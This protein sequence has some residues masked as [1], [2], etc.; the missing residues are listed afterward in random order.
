MP[1]KTIRKS[2][3]VTLRFAPYMFLSCIFH[4]NHL[5]K[6][7]ERIQKKTIFAEPIIPPSMVKWNG[8][9]CGNI[10]EPIPGLECGN[11]TYFAVKDETTGYQLFP[12][13]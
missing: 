3:L 1:G 12:Y 8:Y 13:H 9:Y 6:S 4:Y 10:F 5:W 11:M 2:S 7:L